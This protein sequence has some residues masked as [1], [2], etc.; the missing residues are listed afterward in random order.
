MSNST[1]SNAS[2][3]A[4]GIA[5]NPVG[6]AP[7]VARRAPVIANGVLGMIIF[8]ITE[9]MFFTGLVS[10]F[11]ITRASIGPMSWPPPNQPRLPVASTAVN[12]LALLLSAAVLFRAYML[13]RREQPQAL[14]TLGFAILLGTGFLLG[15][16]REWVALLREGLTLRSSV[17]GS[18]FYIIVG[19]HGL[20]AL[21]AL[22]ALAWCFA[23]LRTG[24]LR[25]ETL[26]ATSVFWYFVAGIWPILYYQ[27]YL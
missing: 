15:Q 3:I 21:C 26:A 24:R 7:Q 9:V 16:G 22:I 18:F 14:R 13:R 2:P 5:G 12:T 11:L 23:R 20:H 8:V 27:I 10:A 4:G 25:T 6:G 1:Q 17:H 19:C